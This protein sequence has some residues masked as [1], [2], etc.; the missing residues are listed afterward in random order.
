MEADILI[1]LDDDK[2]KKIA[3][4]I[5]NKTAK[6]ILQYLTDKQ[7]TVTDIAYRLKLP[8]NTVDYNIKKLVESG[9][10]ER[11]SFWWSVK[12]RKMHTYGIS[13]KRII[14]SPKSWKNTRKYGLTF[15]ITGFIALIAKI[16]TFLNQQVIYR[17]P[18]LQD[19]PRDMLETVA[20]VATDTSG[21]ILSKMAESTTYVSTPFT[22]GPIGWFLIGAWF[23]ILLLVIFSF[24][25][26]RRLK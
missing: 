20:E 21:S 3:E 2:S 19:M 4:V 24:I 16:Y 26:E 15:I 1:S 9:L 8:I 18:D 23:S 6:K 13:N 14:I 7:G 5:S 12:G 10:I 25:S 17:A 22:F 11:K